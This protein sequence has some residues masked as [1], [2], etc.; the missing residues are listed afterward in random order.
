MNN[1]DGLIIEDK[2]LLLDVARLIYDSAISIQ[3]FYKILGVDLDEHRVDAGKVIAELS[4]IFK[5]WESNPPS[6]K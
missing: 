3:D 5:G 6:K 2:D 4:G 1:E